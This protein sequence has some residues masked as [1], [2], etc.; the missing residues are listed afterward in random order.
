MH[1]DSLNIIIFVVAALLLG[2]VI[3]I[4]MRNRSVP[5]T[6]M[7]L[8]AG[9]AAATLC[10]CGGLGHGSFN[11]I[12]HQVGS[13]DPH[14]IL[15]L[16]LPTLIFESAYSME[17][18]LFFR[19]APQIVV[20]AIAGLIISMLLSALVVS[21]MLPWGFAF[22]LLFGALISATDPVAVVALLKEKS[23]RK[24]LETLIEGESLLN[25][26]TAI[27]FFSLFY[28]FAAGTSKGFHG[29]GF[30]AEFFW[31]VIGGIIIG[32]TIGWAILWIIGKIINQPMIEISLSIGAAYLTF[33]VAEEIHVSGIVALVALALLFSSI[34]RTRISPTVSHFLQQFW[35]MMAYIAN[36]LIFLLVGIV[37]AHQV[38][39]PSPKLWLIL[40]ALYLL[41]TLIR[42]ASIF[43]LFPLLKK[44][45]PKIDHEKALVLTWGGLRGAVSLALALSLAQDAA[46]AQQIREQILFLTAGIVVLTI[47][48]NGSSMEWLLA[49]LNLDRLPPAKE[50]TIKKAQQAL[51]QQSEDFLLKIETSPFFDLIRDVQLLPEPNNIASDSPM[52]KNSST[53]HKQPDKQLDIAFMRQLLGIERSAYWNQF[54]KGYI[55]RHTSFILTHAVEQALDNEPVIAPRPD[56]DHIFK[57]PSHPRWL[58]RIPM[59]GHSVNDWLFSRL[60]LGYDVARGF[61]EA[62]EEMRK[63]LD[64]LARGRFD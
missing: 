32:V 61:V 1:G 20:L 17:P 28:A 54:E 27:V 43:S 58:Y 37:I 8:V 41:L 10:R 59:M 51:E 56:L 24:R 7:L 30:I 38:H 55:G 3:K 64:E 26:G 34:G 25:D 6:V 5:Y 16:F 29:A 2:A 62:Q 33:I 45:G 9:I 47:A 48:I 18:H 63:H 60:S 12:I 23:S 21:V 53:L 4:L 46:I 40:I 50:A 52:D 11:S 19:T 44:I 49:R 15:Y 39:V 31:V 22:A 13:I 14:L 36:T 42:A 35:E 57:T